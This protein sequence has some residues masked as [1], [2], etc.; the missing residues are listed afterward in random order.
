MVGAAFFW[1]KILRN[2]E[3]GGGEDHEEDESC[4]HQDVDDK[5]DDQQ[6][7]PANIWGTFQASFA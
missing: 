2:D 5:V 6:E 4:R 3:P 7:N 1:L